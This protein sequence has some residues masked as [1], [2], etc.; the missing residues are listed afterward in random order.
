MIIEFSD[1]ECPFCTRARDTI[2]RLMQD[3]PDARLVYMQYPVLGLHPGAMLP[4]EAALEAHRQGKFWEYHD[5]LFERG[6]RVNR[7]AALE[8]AEELGLDVARFREALERRTH[9]AR[10]EREMRIGEELGVT[11]TPTFFINGY[12]IMG[13][14]P[15]ETFVTVYNL[16]LSASRRADPAEPPA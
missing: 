11:A 10:V 9:R 7:A 5:V 4:A 15:Y 13:A 1:F 6:G 8:I 16:L 14:Q 12:K 3:R 2:H